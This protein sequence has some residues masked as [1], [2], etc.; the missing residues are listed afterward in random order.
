[1]TP[2][3]DKQTFRNEDLVLK[4]T[5]NIDPSIWDESKYEP[6][7]DELCGFREYQKEAV[8]TVLRYLIG[9]KY[10]NLRALAQEN[11]D[12]SQE[13]QRRYG[14]WKGMESHLQ[15]PDQLACSIDMATAT[16][17]SY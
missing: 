3:G 2:K 12:A 6:F 14:S 7:L 17:K 4:V 13:M 9:S 10:P 5:K 15:L 16:G 11:F 8:R 1:M